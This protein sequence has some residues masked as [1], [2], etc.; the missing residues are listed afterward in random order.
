MKFLAG[1]VFCIVLGVA[2]AVGYSYSGLVDITATNPD[3]P[4]VGWLLHNTYRY[5]VRQGMAN[6]AVPANLATPERIKAGAKL[7]SDECVYCHGSPGEDPS[8][9]AKGLNPPAPMLLA[10]SGPYPANRAFWVAKNGVRMS[11]M[12]AWGKSYDDDHLWSVAAFLSQ[13]RGL[14]ADEYKALTAGD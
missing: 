7:Y 13:K 5:S 11:A 9:M 12:P 6:V 14:S 4:A 3:N 2:G 8:A 10:G 1:F